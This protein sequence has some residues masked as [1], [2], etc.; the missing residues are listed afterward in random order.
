MPALVAGC[1]TYTPIEATQVTPGMQV[2]ARVTANT[3]D[4]L[5]SSLGGEQRV[6]SGV[7]TAKQG[8]GLTLQVPTVPMGNVNAQQGLYQQIALAPSDVLELESK[9]LNRQ[10]TGLLIGAGVAA[11][12]VAAAFLAT[13]SSAGADAP[14][15]PESNFLI[16]LLRLHF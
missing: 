8:P 6:M 12:G 14:P 3:A 10:R 15:P 13:G 16:G 2:R 9:T 4:R 1:Y 11:V 5:A 7:V